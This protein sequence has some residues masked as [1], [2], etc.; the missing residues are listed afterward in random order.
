MNSFWDNTD[1]E[2]YNY[3]YLFNE[4]FWRDFSITVHMET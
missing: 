4:N 3:I 1:E 2:V